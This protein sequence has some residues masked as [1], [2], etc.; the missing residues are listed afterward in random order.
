MLKNKVRYT[1]CIIVLITGTI[2][3]KP[4][5]YDLWYTYV[6]QNSR[7]GYLHIVVKKLDNG[8]YRYI[9][10]SKMLIDMLGEHEQAMV[11]RKECVV[12]AKYEPISLNIV[13]EQTSGKITASG[14]IKGD[15]FIITFTR[16]GLEQKHTFDLSNR[17]IFD[18]CLDD[19]LNEHPKKTDQRISVNII[20]TETFDVNP[21]VTICEQKDDSNSLWQL[22][23]GTNLMKGTRTY[24]NDGVMLEANYNIPKMQ[25]ILCTAEDA[26]NITYL[27]LQGKDL[28]VFPLNKNIK[29][30]KQ[31][32]TLEVKLTWKNIPFEKFNFIDWHQEIMWKTYKNGVYQAIL[33]IKNPGIIRS[34]TPYPIKTKEYAP[35]LAETRYIKPNN[36]DI[37]ATAQKIVEGKR[38]AL[39]AVEA[40]SAW[41]FDYIQPSVILET[42]SGPEVL[43]IK[44]GKCT[45]SATLFASLAR[46]IGIPVRIV[47]GERMMSK[48]WF[49]HMWVEAY[50]GY[51]LPVDPALN[52]IGTSFSLLKLKHSNTLDGTQDLRWALTDNFDIKIEDFR[53]IPLQE[54]DNTKEGVDNTVYSNKDFGCRLR[55]PIKNWVID[56]ERSS[57]RPIVRIVIPQEKENAF[58]YFVPFKVPKSLSPKL[59]INM[60]LNKYKNDHKDFE[61]L[62][63]EPYQMVNANGH[64]SKFRRASTK[65][66][67][68]KVL[69]TEVIW[70]KNAFCYLLNF[71]AEESVYKKYESDFFKLISA[72]EYIEQ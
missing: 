26:N 43:K 6:H 49:G 48:Q 9:A 55:L 35:Y 54:K 45:E 46:S 11:F 16:S 64:I 53:T 37:R 34:K 72:I 30:Y 1:L 58:I 4:S 14:E 12:T 40:I 31:L 56:V 57:P 18:L 33:E 50:V 65:N 19:F 25:M 28:L 59:L 22:D 3:G 13:G 62:K 41:V 38:T 44:R 20:N 7:Y 63:D 66:I 5:E 52:D 10:E 23:V 36:S 39:G 68:E 27:K 17:P 24:R 8:N 32:K 67:S 42:L 47:L 69:T 70:G 29:H 21:A 61:L 71:Y 60:R 51:W 15:E 2:M